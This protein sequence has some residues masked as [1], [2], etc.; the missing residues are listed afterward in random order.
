MF[1]VSCAPCHGATGEGAQGQAHGMRPP[2]LTR[3]VFQAGGRDEDLFG[4]IAKGTSAG[5]PSFEPLGA[6]QIRNLVAFV[7]TLSRPAGAASGD[8]ATGEALFWGRA[9]A[10]DVTPS[11]RGAPIWARI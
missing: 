8:P 3:G 1:A 10:A 9:I 11:D 6:D 5:M 4:V 7:R 2:D